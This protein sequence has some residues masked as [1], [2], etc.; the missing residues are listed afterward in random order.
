V[1][2]LPARASL[3]TLGEILEIARQDLG[4]EA[5]I[6]LDQELILS[7]ECP[8]CKTTEH[9]LKPISQVSFQAAHCPVCG[10][11]REIQMAH[12]I[13]GEEPFLERTLASVGVPPLHILRAYN[14]QEYRFYELSGDLPEALHFRHFE[15]P[16]VEPAA[17]INTKIRLGEELALDELAEKPFNGRITLLDD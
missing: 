13:S 10:T 4:D 11:L 17:E 15:K 7:L 9:V 12:S 6:E 14:A 1:V 8:V 16:P 2:E 3:T 5:I